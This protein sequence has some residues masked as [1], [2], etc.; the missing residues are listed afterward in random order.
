MLNGY[1]GIFNIDTYLSFWKTDLINELIMVSV[2]F[3]S[4]MVYNSA[5]ASG[6][7]WRKF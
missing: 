4:F 6:A 3:N 1:F 7:V 5:Q 2:L